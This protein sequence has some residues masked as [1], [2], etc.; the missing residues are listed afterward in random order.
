MAR[1]SDLTVGQY[2]TFLLPRLRGRNHHIPAWPPDV[3]GLCASLLIK[4]GAYSRV[5]SHWPPAKYSPKEASPK[6]WAKTA[7]RV[8]K[9]WRKSWVKS[10]T[11]PVRVQMLWNKLIAGKDIPLQIMAD[12]LRLCQCVL[13]LCGFADECGQGMGSPLDG[14]ETDIDEAF[15]FHAS[16]LLQRDRPGS[17]VAGE[18]HASRLRVLPKMHT[19]QSGLT[20]RSLSLYLALCGPS[21]VVPKWIEPI[22]AFEDH[23]LNL[24]VVPWPTQIYPVQFREAKPMPTEMRNMPDRFRFFTFD[25]QSSGV[26]NFVRILYETAKEQTGR[27]DGVVLPELALST[28]EHLQLREFV[29]SNGSFLVSGVGTSSNSPVEPGRNEV[30][31]DLPLAEPLKQGKHHRWKLDASQISQYSLGGR[32]DPEC[33]WWEHIKLDNREFLFAAFHADIVLSV[34]ICEDL[35]RPD[36]VGDLVR[37]V[38]PNLVIAVL[39]DAPQVKERWAGRYA[40]AL[41][42]DPGCSV[43]SVTSLGM[44][45]LSRPR[46][47][48]SRSRVIALWKDSKTG[49]CEIEMEEGSNAVVLSL[50]M[51][52]VQEWS[53]DGRYGSSVHPILSG[54]RCIQQLIVPQGP[55]Q[56]ADRV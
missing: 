22:S 21:E 3:F 28:D 46:E 37:A 33:E 49:T 30:C 8:A 44:S 42:D 2:L 54:V 41:A 39:M 40:N 12:D 34:L 36:P 53:A 17:S 45:K 25:G 11:A 56:D 20:V 31:L 26:L 29:L 7:D 23:S 55:S 10:G 48:K 18:I 24:L 14:D 1:A 43:L 15:L 35:A 32:L 19:P 50:S 27:I 5:L 9:S 47:G 38:A 52:Y 4:S 13:E 6:S 16:D 51:R